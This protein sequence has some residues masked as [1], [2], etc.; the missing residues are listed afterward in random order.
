MTV[1]EV[2]FRVGYEAPQGRSFRKIRV[3]LYRRTPPKEKLDR[4]REP[5]ENNRLFAAGETCRLVH[6]T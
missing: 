3:N 1:A 2:T 5:F 4:D 6:V